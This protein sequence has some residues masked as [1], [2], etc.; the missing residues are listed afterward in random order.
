MTAN[1]PL[2]TTH[3]LCALFYCYIRLLYRTALYDIKYNA[4]YR[5]YCAMQIWVSIWYIFHIKSRTKRLTWMKTSVIQHKST[6]PEYCS[7]QPQIVVALTYYKCS[8]GAEMGD[9]LATT[10]MG[11]KLGAVPLSAG[12]ASMWP[13]PRPTFVPSGILIHPAVWPQQTWAENWGC[14]PFF[15]G[16]GS[17]VP[18]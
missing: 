12:A 4:P 13:G 6:P 5:T 7:R 14:A 2:I 10:D 9:S 1:S 17:W 15:W 8:A 3:A 11:Q 18:I 16:G